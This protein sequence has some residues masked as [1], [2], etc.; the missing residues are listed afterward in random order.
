MREEVE[1]T[2]MNA[3]ITQYFFTKDSVKANFLYLV[4]F[5]FILFGLLVDPLNQV[6]DGFL[7][8]LTSPSNLITDYFEVGGIGAT[9]VNAGLLMLINAM[10]IKRFST[11]ITGPLV[12]ALF[13][14]MGF[15]FFGKNLYNSI[16]ITLG[17]LLYSQY[18]N[19]P[20][21]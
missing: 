13:T 4:S 9:F 14:V 11:K 15:A 21:R 1:K 3:K 12:A 2:N 5:I 10:A 7:A 18:R 20:I 16:P 19:M 6:W 8:I 17:T